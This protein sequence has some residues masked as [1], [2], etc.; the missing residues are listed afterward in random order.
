MSNELDY[1][2]TLQEII[3]AMAFADAKFW[4]AHSAAN[5]MVKE[6]YSK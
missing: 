6:V 1:E 5:K 4:D 2:I 3:A